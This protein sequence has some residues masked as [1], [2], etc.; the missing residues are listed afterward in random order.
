M[1]LWTVGTIQSGVS[2]TWSRTRKLHA[3]TFLID[4]PSANTTEILLNIVGKGRLV[5]MWMLQDDFPHT[6]VPKGA[7]W[8]GNFRFYI[9]N[10]TKV[11]AATTAFVNGDKIID[12]NGN[13]QTVTAGG[14]GNSGGSPPT[15]SQ[16]AAGT[17]TDNA[18]TWTQTPGTP[19][20]VWQAAKAY[21]LNMALVDTN[22]N[23]Q[24]VTT[25]GTSGGSAPSWNVTGGGTTTDNTVTWTNQGSTYVHAGY[26]SSGTEDYFLQGFYGNGINAMFSSN[27]DVGTTFCSTSPLSSTSPTRS[28]FRFHV[29]DPITFD[30]S[31][32]ITWQA[33]D[34]SQVAISSGAAKAWV[35]VYYYTES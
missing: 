7:A 21:A 3:D 8:E 14:G 28:F 11:W 9:D 10:A 30:S 20:Q 5:G 12:S 15:W 16:A 1:T 29:D 6:L 25:A 32:V 34:T 4:S 26:Q 19:N 24:R 27:G 35:T 2:N 22:G 31:I 13:L 17:T 33:F 18:L 23:V